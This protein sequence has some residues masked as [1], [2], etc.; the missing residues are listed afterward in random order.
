MWEDTDLFE[1]PDDIIADLSQANDDVVDV[2][3]IKRGMISAF[4]SSLVQYQIPAVYWW[5]KVLFFPTEANNEKV[6]YS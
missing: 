4:S 5:K 6:K 3:V 2:D 1:E